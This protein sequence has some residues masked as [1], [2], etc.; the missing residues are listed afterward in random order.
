M[1]KN[2]FV[3]T[4]S[5]LNRQFRLF[6]LLFPLPFIA[7]PLIYAPI[8]GVNPKLK[9]LLLYPHFEQQLFME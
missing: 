7:V 5:D 4:F 8:H 1:S 6:K 3:R 9:S 2:N